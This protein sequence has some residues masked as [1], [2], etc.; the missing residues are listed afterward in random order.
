M[1]ELYR[2]VRRIG[3]G[4]I[5]VLLLGETGAGKEVVARQLHSMSPRHG[6][7]LRA[8]NCAAIPDT[9][10]ESVLFGH[11]RGAFTGAD[12]RHQGIFEQAHGG[13]V[14]L[15]EV[16]ELSLS[17]QASLLRVLDTGRVCPV[18]A[19]SEVAVDVRVLSATHRDLKD[20]VR[21]GAFRVDLLHRLN[22]FVLEVPPLRERRDDIPLLAEQFVA[23][24]SAR[25]GGK[26]TGIDEETMTLLLAHDWPGN[27]RELRNV[28]ERGLAIAE[29]DA[30]SAADLP[31]D[32]RAAAARSADPAASPASHRLTVGSG[33]DL[34]WELRSHE[35]ALIRRALEEAGGHQP[36][37]A[38][39]LKIPLRTLERKL[40]QHR[41][42]TRS[43]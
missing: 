36:T 34:R 41:L 11:V 15:D 5:P 9:L 31:H 30:L 1:V 21:V 28:V 19:T 16:G 40:R 23:E 42:R 26:V 4:T 3:R 12:R 2:V 10:I 38:R 33:V 35:T 37:A 22:A 29:G 43:C 32:L 20:M 27:V 8:V 17:A 25:W 18:G 14:L 39:L 24:L 7:P 13:A 6:I